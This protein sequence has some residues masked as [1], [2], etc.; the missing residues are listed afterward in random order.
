MAHSS[1]L[2]TAKRRALVALP[3]VFAFVAILS[4]RSRAPHG[5]VGARNATPA[6]WDGPAK[7]LHRSYGTDYP[8]T[9]G[10]DVVGPPTANEV[11]GIRGISVPAPSGTN[12]VLEYNSGAYS[13]AS[14]GGGASVTGTGL[15][16]SASGSLNSAAV[17]LSQDVT[18]GSLSS[19]NLPIT[20]TQARNGA[21]GFGTQG[22]ITCAAADTTCEFLQA[23]QTSDLAPPAVTISAAGPY[24]GAS[25]NTTSGDVVINIP[26]SVGSGY[27]LGGFAIDYNN[28]EVAAI[29]TWQNQTNQGTIWLG[30]NGSRSTTNWILDYAAG[31]AYLNGASD[32]Q[33]DFANATYAYWEAGGLQLFASSTSFGG[34]SGVLGMANAGTIPSSVCTSGLCLYSNSGALEINPGSYS[35]AAV[36]FNNNTTAATIGIASSSGTGTG[37]TVTMQGQ[38]M[39]GSGST[40][41]DLSLNGAAGQSLN[42]AVNIQ[43]GGTNIMRFGTGGKGAWFMSSSS[44]AVSTTPITLTTAQSLTPWIT[45]TG[46]TAT[47]PTVLNLAAGGNWFF[48][49]SGAGNFSTDNLKIVTSG[50]SANCLIAT[51]P[52]FPSLQIIFVHAS[53]S[54]ITCGYL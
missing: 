54:A 30:E 13:W 41:G 14:G 12:T 29:G 38:P 22:Q 52:S 18:P 33:I 6:P 36:Q 34:G 32:I 10:G 51:N 50:G 19:S 37:A 31:T 9:L 11:E 16:Y 28:T 46:N 24:S 47:N 7:T 15:W 5:D 45:L 42:G 35:A 48:D 43:S 44:I 1:Y 8:V 39:T 49:V 26:A 2:S 20:V 3:L 23:A 17:T 40:G 25:T 21:I 53:S 27:K 4:C